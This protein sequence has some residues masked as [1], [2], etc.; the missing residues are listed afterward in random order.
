MV[1][2]SEVGLGCIIISTGSRKQYCGT[3]QEVPITIH[4][5]F[6]TER[7]GILTSV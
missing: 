7:R 6:G 4:G 2:S 3:G 1:S 5:W